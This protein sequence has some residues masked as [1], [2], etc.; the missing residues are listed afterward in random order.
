VLW[1]SE[2]RAAALGLRPR[3]TLLHQ[4]LTGADPCYLL[5]GPVAATAKVLRRSGMSV[6][7]ID[8]YEVNEAFATVPLNWL[9]QYKADP[10]RLNVNGGAIAVGHPIGATGS[11]L[12]VTALH[13]L[14]R[15]DERTALITMCCGGSLGTAAVLAR[16]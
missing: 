3:A 15:R 16:E 10:D 5:D 13:E 1:M 12:I 2:A 7:D 14:E 8:L 4:T 9:D 6:H 11:R